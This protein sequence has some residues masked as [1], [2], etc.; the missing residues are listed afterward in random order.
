MSAE[1]SNWHP[2]CLSPR[3]G[4]GLGAVPPSP[5]DGD[6]ELCRARVA[7]AAGVPI[8][9][10][11]AG[12]ISLRWTILPT[13]GTRATLVLERSETELALMKCVRRRMNGWQ[14]TAP[15]GGSVNVAYDYEFR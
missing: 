15:E 5:D 6:L 11:K 8:E 9:E 1:H 13:G 7:S 2:A 10:V 14:F 12:T 4:P 3:W